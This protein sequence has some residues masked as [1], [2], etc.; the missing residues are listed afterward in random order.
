MI[1]PAVVYV[2]RNGKEPDPGWDNKLGTVKSPF[3]EHV[4]TQRTRHNFAQVQGVR[5][6]W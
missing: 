1:E 6:V 4:K 5:T 2:T 3:M